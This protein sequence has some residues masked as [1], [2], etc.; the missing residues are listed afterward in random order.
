MSYIPESELI[1]NKEG[2]IYHLNLRPEDI[3]DT[4]ITVGDPARVERISRHFDRI[5]TKRCKNVNL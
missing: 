5:D 3:A 4:I 1:L 2:R